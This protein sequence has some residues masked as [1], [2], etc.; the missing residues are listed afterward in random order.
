M[1]KFTKGTNRCLN[2]NGWVDYANQLLLANELLRDVHDVKTKWQEYIDLIFVDEYQDTDPVQY[3]IVTTL[4]D[5]HQNLRVVGDDDQGIYSFRGADIQNILNFEKEYSTAKVIPL[6]Q[7][8]RST[9]RIVEA[10]KALA[11]FNPDRREKDL[12]TQNS[13]GENVKHLHCKNAEEEGHY[14]NLFYQSCYPIRLES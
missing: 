3:R 7:N 9:Q 4:A 10:S 1:W 5:H 2:I 12:F 11:E 6:G 14:Y 13:D 8:Y